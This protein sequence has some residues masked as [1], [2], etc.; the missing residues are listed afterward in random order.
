VKVLITGG[1]GFLGRTTVRALVAGGHDVRLIVRD[2]AKAEAAFNG[3]PVT[4][5]E[6]NLTDPASVDAAVLGCDAVVHAAATY[7][8]D[9]AGS[10]SMSDNTMAARIVFEAAMRADVHRVVDVASTVVFSLIPRRID[11]DT[12]LTRPGEPGWTDPY[13]RSKVEAEDLGRELEARGLPRVT[14]Y[15]ALIVGPDDAVPGPSGSVVVSILKGSP[16]PSIRS[17]WVDVRDV[18]R[19]IV[20]ALDA[21]VGSRYLL[22]E[23]VHPYRE[24]NALLAK[25]TGRRIRGLFLP[26]SGLRIISRIND[27][28]GGRLGPYPR[29]GSLEFLLRSAPVVDSAAVTTE[30]GI[31]YTPFEKTLTDS[32]RWWVANGTIDRRLAGRLA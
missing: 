3:L 15:P 13:L 12:P 23:G 4:I 25:V 28:A 1:T 24:I 10:A 5:V 26:G 22:A 18:A 9:W 20:G 29:A 8:Y 6:G 7:T 30:L 11:V 14:V 27:A 21:P 19:A 16:M 32:V 2:R 17:P 31:A